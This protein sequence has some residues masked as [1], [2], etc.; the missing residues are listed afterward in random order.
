MS[1]DRYRIDTAD[2]ARDRDRILQ[3][4]ERVGFSAT[5]RADRY[6]WFY[7]RNPD[8]QGRIYVLVLEDGGEIVGTACAGTRWMRMPDDRLLRAS[9]LVD[10]AVDPAHRS[11]GPALKLQRATRDAELK[12]ADLLFGLP[13]TKAVPIFKRLGCDRLLQ[14]TSY[15]Y[16]LRSGP[17][18]QRRIPAW[19]APLGVAAGWTVDVVR[20]ALLRLWLLASGFRPTWESA[21][22]AGVDELWAESGIVAGCTV[23]VR[24]RRFLGWRFGSAGWRFAVIRGPAQTGIVAYMACR[25]TGDELHIGD[26]LLPPGEG[27]KRY[28]LLS[29][30]SL[31]RRERVR[32]ARVD[33]SGPAETARVLRE[34]GFSPRSERP[35]FIVSK[36]N[37]S[38]EEISGDWWFTK[39]DEDV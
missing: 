15:A 5:D 26:L 24:D 14:E 27:P 19:A 31:L 13:D 21:P 8:G 39:A 17:Y 11:V 20:S 23:G 35:C 6:D 22:P 37:L 25:I 9:V 3:F 1:A 10:F 36:G 33:L 12:E 4:W 29:F 18:I 2:P 30:L 34:T 32:V 7:L 16:V 38:A 28:A